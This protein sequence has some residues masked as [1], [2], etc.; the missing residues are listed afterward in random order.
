MKKSIIFLFAFC[1]IAFACSKDESLLQDEDLNVLTELKSKK[2][3]TKTLSIKRSWGTMEMIFMDSPCSP[4]SYQFVIN[5]QG[6]ANLLGRFTVRNEVC[7][8]PGED[9]QIIPQ[10][11]W[12]GVLTA[13]NGD[14][15]HTMLDFTWEG[16]GYYYI[17]IDGTGKFDGATGY[18]IMTGVTDYE[19]W[20]YELKGEG[21]ITY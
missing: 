15:I 9:G 21:E 11:A 5:G 16:E 13:A 1:F 14:E 6:N 8:L 4:D 10:S 20:T 19:T 2:L 17:I 18:I 7:F 3:K 12:L